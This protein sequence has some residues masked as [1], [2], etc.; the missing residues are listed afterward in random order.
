MN[1]KEISEI[2]RLFTPSG[3]SISRICGCY[4]DGEKNKKTEIKEAFL[5]LPE[6]D[7][8]K[9][10]EILRK[11][12]SGSLGKNLVNLAFPLDSEWEGGT[13]EFLLRLRNSR[14]QDDELLEAFYDR[15]IEAYDYVGNY[16]ILIIDDAYDIPGR[17]SDRLSM[18]DASDEVFHYILCCICPVDLSKPGL[19]YNEVDNTFQNRTR[20]WAVGLPELGF[21]FP[22]FNDRSTDIH[23]TLYYSKNHSDLHDG[24]IEQLLGCP[25]P[26]AA[27]FQK[28]SFQAII[29]ETLGHVCDYETVKT[30]YENLS[31]ML[32][33]HKDASEPLVLDKYQVRTLLENSGVEEGQME[34]FDKSFNETAGEKAAIYAGNLINPRVFEVKTPDVIIK[35]NPE[36]TDLVETREIDGRQCLVIAV[37]GGVEVNGIKVWKDRDHES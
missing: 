21:L 7:M 5:S 34:A 28:E 37:D 27:D 11:T 22:S 36:R 9:Y 8:F 13:Q 19:S 18:D 3:C 26:L 24:F 15:I 17:T 4:V 30:I 31:E 33:E 35:I 20:D 25:L 32:E 12:L 10:F 6:E 23:S 16:L 2:K 14:L 1:K 29:E